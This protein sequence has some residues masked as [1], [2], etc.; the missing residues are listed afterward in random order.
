M[1]HSIPIDIVRWRQQV[2]AKGQA[3][4]EEEQVQVQPWKGE[5]GNVALRPAG[6]LVDK[7]QLDSIIRM[8]DYGACP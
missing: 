1:V 6:T 4:I 8:D 2:L 7:M 5:K 3:I